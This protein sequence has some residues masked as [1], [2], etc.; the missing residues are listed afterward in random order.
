MPI[1]PEKIIIDTN[2]W[3]SYLITKDYLWLDKLIQNRQVIL[4]FSNELMDE[5]LAVVNRP[6]LSHYFSQQDLERL[7][8]IIDNYCIFYKEVSTVKICR[9]FKD[10][11]LLSLAKDSKSDYLLS[12]DKDLLDLRKFGR[13]KI[14]TINQ[15][16]EIIQPSD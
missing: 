12:G 11:F 3:I 6:R 14:I 10:D 7:L 1:K 9:D 13:T 4:V 16:K 2:I 5:F 15:F 8:E